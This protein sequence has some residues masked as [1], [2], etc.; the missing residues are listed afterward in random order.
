MHVT[1]T[2][3]RYFEPNLKKK[4]IWV[5]EMKKFIT[6]KVTA[7]ALKTISRNGAYST[8]KKAGIVA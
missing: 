6:V 2:T 5:S 7:R 4:R 8:L 1:A 3:T